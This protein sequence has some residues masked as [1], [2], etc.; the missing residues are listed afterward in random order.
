MKFNKK[1]IIFKNDRLGDL[2]HSIPA[3][4]NVI[5]QNPDKEIIIFLSKISKSFYFLFKK[6]NTRLEVLNYHLT[7]FEKIKILKYLIINKL[8]KIYILSPKN[9]YFYLPL[10]FNKIKFFG[11][12]MNGINRYRRPSSFLRKFLYK[13]AINDRETQKKRKSIQSLLFELTSNDLENK[14]NFHF[15]LDIPKSENLKKYL[16]NNYILV[17]FK[18]KVAAKLDWGE[19]ELHIILNHLKKY[20]PNIVLIKDIEKDELNLNFRKK[21]KTLD[22]ENN[23]FYNNEDSILFFDNIEGENL[24][25]L[26]KHSKKVIAFHGTIP[27][28]ALLNNTPV[29][30]LFYCDIKN[31]KD[32]HSYKNAFYEFKPKYNGY[33]FIIPSKDVKKTLKKMHFAIRN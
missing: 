8:Q 26:V 10:V 3:I 28:I 2:L 9:F 4:N 19:D 5:D 31:I 33:D 21:Y 12:C 16:P 6:E 11:L 29:L 13:F 32:Y 24:Y 7:L 20:N 30:D 15:K 14:N 22:F 25:N 18:K 1:I 23:L 27:S 17:H